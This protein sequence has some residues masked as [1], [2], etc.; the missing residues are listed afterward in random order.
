MAEGQRCAPTEF[1]PREQAELA[2][3]AGLLG[4]P[5]TLRKVPR[6]SLEAHEM[7]LAACRRRL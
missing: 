4:A 3:V 7:L 5:R 6:N 2:A 1:R